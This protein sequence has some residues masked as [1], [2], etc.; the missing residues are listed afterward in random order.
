MKAMR[1]RLA[2][3]SACLTMLSLSGCGTIPVPGILRPVFGPRPTYTTTS[4]CIVD[5]DASRGLRVVEAQKE[6]GSGRLFVE[7]RGKRRRLAVSKEAGYAAQEPWFRGDAPIRQYTRRY[8]KYGPRRTVPSAALTRGA[9]H[10]G[11]PVFL[12]L[13]DTKQPKALYVPV[14]PGCVF[15]PYIDDRYARS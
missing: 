2:L 13:K 9:D 12:D 7:E 5:R 4:L 14:E 8:V 15:Q 10:G 6:E 11:V 3:G 1:L